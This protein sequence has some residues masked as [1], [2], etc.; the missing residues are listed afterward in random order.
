MNFSEWNFTYL[1][2]QYLVR[3]FDPDI[4]GCRQ[5]DTGSNCMVHFTSLHNSRAN[6]SHHHDINSKDPFACTYIYIRV[7]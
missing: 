5:W 7:K 6:I 2:Q 3:P 4:N 1:N